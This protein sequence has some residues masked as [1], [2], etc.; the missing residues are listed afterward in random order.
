MLYDRRGL[1]RAL[2]ASELK[3]GWSFSN[4]LRNETLIVLGIFILWYL[5][6]I[7]FVLAKK[8]KSEITKRGVLLFLV[9]G[10]LLALFRSWAYWY[11]SYRMRTHTFYETLRP[12]MLCLLPEAA[13]VNL[14]PPIENLNWWVAIMYGALIIGSFLWTFPL[15]LF[16]A[17]RKL[18]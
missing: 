4:M 3:A 17:R 7:I 2:D 14:L 13:L 6:A 18:P 9:C 12:L 10:S 8:R 1:I 11:L 5:A 16:L 15:I